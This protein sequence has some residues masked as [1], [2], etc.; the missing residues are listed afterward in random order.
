MVWWLRLHGGGISQIILR[1]FAQRNNMKTL[2]E[3]FENYCAIC[4]VRCGDKF[5]CEKHT[6][7]CNAFL[8]SKSC[9]GSMQS[10]IK[11]A[12]KMGR[13][14]ADSGYNEDWDKGCFHGKL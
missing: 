13:E 6:K 9:D 2:E 11:W 1:V 3:F 12:A 4:D 5:F 14:S 10:I 8:K 7:A